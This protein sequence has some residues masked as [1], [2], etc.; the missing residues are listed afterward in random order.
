MVESIAKEMA[1]LFIAML[2]AFAQVTTRQ[3]MTSDERSALARRLSSILNTGPT[4]GPEK[5]FEQASQ[6]LQGTQPCLKP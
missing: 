2:D 5:L 6:L 3:A 4:N 1:P